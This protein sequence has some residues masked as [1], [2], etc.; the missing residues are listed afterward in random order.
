MIQREWE[1]RHL[2]LFIDLWLVTNIPSETASGTALNFLP[3]VF[4]KSEMNNM[5]PVHGRLIL[6][7]RFP[8][9]CHP[10]PS[11]IDQLP[12][13]CKQYFRPLDILCHIQLY[14]VEL[15]INSVFA[16]INERTNN[17]LTY[18]ITISR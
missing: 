6:S 2:V 12:N 18:E 1:V 13:L 3:L 8:A 7:S 14:L 9:N 5:Y 16:G 17:R 15:D 11:N 4:M 10:S